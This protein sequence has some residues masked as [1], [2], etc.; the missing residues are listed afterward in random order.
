MGEADAHDFFVSHASEDKD[1]VARPLAEHLR[2]AKYEVWYDEFSL[3]LGDSL[4][5]SIDRG[6]S[7]SRY[8]VLVLSPHFFEKPWPKEELDA[9]TT[10]RMSGKLKALLPVWHDVD[11]A[12]VE[13]FSPSLAGKV[14]V[15]TRF[16][17]DRVMGDIV[18]AVETDEA[19]V[20]RRIGA[21]HLP[22]ARALF[23]I[24]ARGRD[25]QSR[26]LVFQDR[27]WE[28]CLLPNLHVEG[29]QLQDEDDPY[30]RDRLATSLGVR[31]GQVHAAH[32][33]GH[34][35]RSTKYS[36]SRGR[37]AT[38]HFHLFAATCEMAP[39]CCAAA[40]TSGA[41][42]Y[43]WLTL[44]ELQHSVNAE[45]NMDVY[46]HLRRNEDAILNEVPVSCALD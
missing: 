20:A 1:A 22:V 38:Y 26:L 45:R 14:G 12:A 36:R 27:V 17:L 2:R 32:L 10:L 6:L 42:D 43:L 13:A 16:G 18:R 29:R 8:G 34:E 46:E 21:A 35:L 41:R 31:S 4:R 3:R 19:E 9:L 39:E 24:R 5:E 15:P 44:A 40:F 37:E 25:G 30:L 11:R 7:A 33:A 28:C 23:L